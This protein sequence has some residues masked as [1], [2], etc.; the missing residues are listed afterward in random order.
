MRTATIAAL[1]VYPIKGCRGVPV[2][3]AE[4][5]ER[6]L[7]AGTAGDREWMI[8]DASGR[9]VSQREHPR[10]ALVRVACNARALQL[11]A[12]GMPSLDVE[13]VD[14]DGSPRR[15]VVVWHST[16]AAIDAGE[17]AAQWFCAY[18]ETTARLV[19]FAPE[20]VR[21]CNP[22]YVGASGAHTAF[23]DGYPLLVIGQASL[24]DL[25]ARL[26]AKGSRTLPMNRFR[27]NVVIAG[28]EPFDEDHIDTIA[29][30]GVTLKLV[31]P[32][33]RC[34]VTTTDQDSAAVGDEPLATLASYR[35][36]ERY[37]GVTFGMNAIV[38]AG[39]S[40]SLQI[41]AKATIDY[42]F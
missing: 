31:K 35:M 34:R 27:P 4:V 18:L 9:F 2:E 20:H 25:N 26:A 14:A 13:A 3:R 29:I 21:A 33:T 19:R 10:L 30:D 8:V 7:A 24:D 11:T 12:P 39:A 32:C 28:L 17:R 6:G 1:N 37:D 42:R 22:Q 38:T 15:D 16:V 40:R 41:G 23:A 36:D 5:T